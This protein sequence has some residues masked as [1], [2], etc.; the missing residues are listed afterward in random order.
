MAG[1]RTTLLALL[2]VDIGP[3]VT[4]WASLATLIW[5]QRCRSA[6]VPVSVWWFV[7]TGLVCPVA[8]V[9]A[10]TATLVRP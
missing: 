1:D 8:C 10:A 6:G 9:A 5:F 3:L 2:V 4:P 7:A